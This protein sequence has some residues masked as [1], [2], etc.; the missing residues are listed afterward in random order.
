MKQK[1]LFAVILGM[2]LSAATVWSTAQEES[3]AKE[4]VHITLFDDQVEEKFLGMLEWFTAETGWP[5][6][7]VPA[8]G[9]QDYFTTNATRLATGEGP[10]ILIGHGTPAEYLVYNPKQ[11]FVDITDWARDTLVGTKVPE[12]VMAAN[13]V[14][15]RNFGIPYS[16][17]TLR[18][19][20]YNK[21]LAQ[22]AGV[23]V[24]ASTGDFI[25][26]VAPKVRAAGFDPLY[27]MGQ[28]A[29]SLGFVADNFV[30]DEF[31]LTDVQDRINNNETSFAETGM[32]RAFEYIKEI[33]DRG[34]FN[35]DALV[36]TTE[37]QYAALREGTVYAAMGS[38]NSLPA[39]TE[40]FNNTKLG[41][42]NISEQGNRAY[43]SLPWFAYLVKEEAGGDNQEGAWAF[44]NWF[45]E[46]KNLT[47]FYNTFRAPSAYLGIENEMF[48]YSADLLAHFRSEVPFLYKLKA[49]PQLTGVYAVT[50]IAGTRTPQEAAEDMQRDFAAS[51]K[52]VG[53]PAYQ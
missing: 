34:F 4:T 30:A 28:S 48:P 36:G 50:V 41:G 9:G 12:A 49:S 33:G 11:N 45:L 10:D 51:A 42:F 44:I 1:A 22:A 7:V 25:D 43:Y 19:Y 16:P 26:N 37:G 53:L 23:T 24:P 17:I 15:G 8:P 6:E 39:F 2:A 32:V 3:A 29:W 40:E 46:Q 52:A 21:E 47:R 35:A 31:V 5:T 14:D 38:V 20:L 27:A 18:G 13:A